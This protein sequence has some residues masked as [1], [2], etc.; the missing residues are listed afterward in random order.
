MFPTLRRGLG[1]ASSHA[2]VRPSELNIA[3]LLP[4]LMQQAC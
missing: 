4:A 3:F 1:V 2:S